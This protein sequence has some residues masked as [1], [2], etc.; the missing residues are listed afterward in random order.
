MVKK[1]LSLITGFTKIDVFLIIFLILLGTIFEI[2]SLGIIIPLISFFSEN[3][4]TSFFSTLL[5]SIFSKNFDFQ[6][7]MKI[8]LVLIFF[9][10]IFRFVFLCF[11]TLKINSF[12]Y[13]CQKNISNK[14]LKIYLG[15]NYDWHTENNK[16]NFINLMT[17]EVYNFCSNGLAGFLF[18]CAELIFFV[19]IILFLLVWEPKIFLIMTL[20]SIIFFPTLILF[21][22]KVSFKLGT[23]RQEMEAKILKSLNENLSGIKEMILYKWSTPVLNSYNNLATQLTK[24]SAKHNSMMEIGRYLI[25]LAGIILVILFIYFLTTSTEDKGNLITLGIF[26]AALFR[27]MPILNRIST[28]SQRL[29]FGMASVNK[30]LDFYKFDET[31]LVDQKTITFTKELEFKNLNFKFKNKH[32]LNNINFKIRSNEVIGIYGESG[33]GKTTL[34]NIIMGLLSPSSGSIYVDGVNITNENLSFSNNIA[35]VPQNFF[36]LD[37]NLLDNITFFDKKIKIKNL[38]FALKNS[39]LTESILN[40]SLSLKTNLGNNALKISGGQLQRI[41][42]ARALYRMPRMLVLDEPTSSLDEKNQILCNK[43]LHQLK[44]KFS[45]LIITHNKKLLDNC[46]NI[47]LL[48]NRMLIKDNSL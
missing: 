28:Y 2:L 34:S 23:T 16:S 21:T 20:I 15:K 45:I 25:E 41:N 7:Q 26:G 14:L 17:T 1:I 10:F 6:D 11:L 46:D 4:N 42:I 32:V 38:K 3:P 12:I 47:Y 44:K 39:L 48:E 19:G 36:Y 33:V 9:V 22:R 37:A 8:L 30:L 29:K 13:T 43:I 35:F 27:L 18:L 24:V 40:K 31:I 5:T